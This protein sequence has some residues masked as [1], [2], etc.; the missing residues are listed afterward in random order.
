MPTVGVEYRYPFISVQS[1]GTQTIEPI[2]QVIARPAEQQIDKWPNEDAQS[3]IFDDSNLL[4][5]DKFSGY[6]RMEGG[7]RANY[8]ISYTAQFNRGGSFN[9]LFGQSYSLWDN[10]FTQGGISNT[11]L[12]SGL[13][14]TRSDYVARATFQPNS[15]YKFSSRF[16]FDSDLRQFRPLDLQCHVWRLC[17]A[18]RYW[19][20]R[21]PSGRAHRRLGQAR[22]QLGAARLRALRH[23]EQ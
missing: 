16:R 22:R 19:L 4:K 3:L 7:G 12:D 15:I 20:P 5:V 8:A 18:T 21:P 23:R 17:R 14:K 11:G 9:A 13:D 10:S 2:A 6:D 1:W